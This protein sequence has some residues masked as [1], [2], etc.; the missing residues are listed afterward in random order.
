MVDKIKDILAW[1][2]FSLLMIMTGVGIA[3][4]GKFLWSETHKTAYS[5]YDLNLDGKVNS[6]DGDIAY[7]IMLGERI[8]TP[9]MLERVDV[10][11]DGLIDDADVVAITDAV[12]GKVEE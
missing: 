5:I 12:L 3:T 1:A 4:V 8:A 2:L 11:K 10:T 7:D 6:Y 9:A